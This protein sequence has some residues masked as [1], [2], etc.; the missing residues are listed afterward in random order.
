MRNGSDYWHT[1]IIEG[2]STTPFDPI[3][4]SSTLSAL[5]GNAAKH[6]MNPTP[7]RSGN[8]TAERIR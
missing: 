7:C 2:T 1:V 5:R 3:N 6:S 4:H 8:E